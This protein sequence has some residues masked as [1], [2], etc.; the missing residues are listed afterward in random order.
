MKISIVI[1]VYNSAKTIGRLVDELVAELSWL[2]IEIVLVND[3]S[4]DDSEEVCIALYRKYPDV[5]RFHSLARNVGEHNA[6]MAGLNN[7]SGDYAVIMDDDFQNPPS[8]VLK[9]VSEAVKND[10]DVVYSYYDR[11]MHSFFR[12]LG[13]WFNDKVANIMLDKPRDLYLSSFKAISRFLVDEI[14]KYEASFPYIDGL[15]LQVTGNI[16]T[17]KVE[18][19]E[20]REGRSNYTLRKLISLWL[21]MFTNFSVIPLR[22]SVFLGFLCSFYGLVYGL[23]TIIQK[24]A[25]PTIAGGWAS[26]I[27]SV[28]IFSGVQLIAIGVIG[29]YVGRIFLGQNKKPQFT[30]KKSYTGRPRESVTAD[31]KHECRAFTAAERP[32]PSA[33]GLPEQSTEGDMPP[34]GGVDL[35]L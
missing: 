2:D 27:V 12:N 10:Y 26:L 24:I 15:I 23:V 18:H 25:D 28:S 8:E 35:K 4:V 31:A 34:V 19:C 7:I 22:V 16:G 13:S 5:V 11:K 9:L 17:V 30:I 33:T 20:R 3:R 29:E 32:M 14:T 1:P 21:N 6:V